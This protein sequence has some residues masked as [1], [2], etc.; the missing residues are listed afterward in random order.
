MVRCV[1]AMSLVVVLVLPAQAVNMPAVG[2]G[3]VSAGNSFS[4]QVTEQVTKIV[5][6]LQRTM[7]REHVAGKLGEK[8]RW[9]AVL[10]LPVLLNTAPLAEAG[11]FS[12][13]G[14]SAFSHNRILTQVA[15]EQVGI[16]EHSVPYQ[17]EEPQVDM[18]G[19]KPAN[20][21]SVVLYLGRGLN[22]TPHG[23]GSYWTAIHGDGLEKAGSTNN[24]GIGFRNPRETTHELK[25]MFF[26]STAGTAEREVMREGVVV[27]GDNTSGPDLIFAW[28]FQLFGADRNGI[29]GP[30]RYAPLS[31][32]IGPALR[33]YAYYYYEQVVSGSDAEFTRIAGRNTITGAILQANLDLFDVGNGVL[34]VSYLGAASFLPANSESLGGF[35]HLVTMSFR[36]GW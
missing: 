8:A 9:L 31:V 15:Q 36:H 29:V 10:A 6:K 11:D 30:F 13:A 14:M 16:E 24:L 28:T 20:G 12:H 1:F 19:S 35:T 34:G 2:R 5:G 25:L 22:Q 17:Q 23:K 32:N 26:N 7:W 33:S 18:W 4:R 21:R 27:E 3:V